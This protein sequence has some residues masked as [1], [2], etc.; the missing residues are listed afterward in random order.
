MF[1]SVCLIPPLLL[2]VCLRC[3]LPAL[4]PWVSCMLPQYITEFHTFVPVFFLRHH[5]HRQA[6]LRYSQTTHHCQ[7]HWKNWFLSRSELN[8]SI[9]GLLYLDRPFHIE[10]IRKNDV[11]DVRVYSKFSIATIT[12]S[13]KH[14]GSPLSWRKLV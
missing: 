10:S 12:L 5:L 1:F 13:I 11:F 8:P 3:A 2:F 6:S 4:T 7:R 14:I 9:I